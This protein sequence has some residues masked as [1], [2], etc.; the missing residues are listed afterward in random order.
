MI[1][2]KASIYNAVGIFLFAFILFCFE[3]VPV[4][5]HLSGFYTKRRSKV[6]SIQVMLCF[7]F[8]Y[9]QGGGI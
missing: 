6:S 8:L 3:M 1:S 4:V 5:N 7:I 9:L 2:L